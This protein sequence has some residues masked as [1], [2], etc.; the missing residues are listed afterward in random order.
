MTHSIYLVR[1]RDIPDLLVGTAET[2][3]EADEIY[4]AEVRRRGIHYEPC[5]R[6]WNREGSTIIDFGSHVFFVKVTP[7][8]EIFEMLG[9]I[10][11]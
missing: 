1:G 10:K 6:F 5:T 7:Q 2:P 4:M 9:E 3:Q 8:F 11:E